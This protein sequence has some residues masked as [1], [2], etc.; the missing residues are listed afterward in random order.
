MQFL[1]FQIAELNPVAFSLQT[2]VT[3][4]QATLFKSA[5]DC[6]VY[7]ES[8]NLAMCGHFQRVP[9]A[10]RFHTKV[11][12]LFS[13]IERFLFTFCS[14]G[15]AKQIAIFGVPEL[16]LMPNRAVLGI[17]DVSTAVVTGFAFDFCVAKLEM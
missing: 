8:Q 10:S 9:F 6:T 13:Q 5:S 11:R 14:R 12:N 16:S 3:P 4:L 15:L 7:P 1:H 2:E 17:A